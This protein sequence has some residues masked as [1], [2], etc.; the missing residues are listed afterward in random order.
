MAL[1]LVGKLAAYAAQCTLHGLDRSQCRQMSVK[2]TELAEHDV[3]LVKSSRAWG[4][5]AD[6]SLLSFSARGI[7]YQLVI[8]EKK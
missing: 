2:I 7:H 8:S 4:G 3:M 1:S 5:G 6:M